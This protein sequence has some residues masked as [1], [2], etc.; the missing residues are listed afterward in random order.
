MTN[1]WLYSIILFCV[2]DT[3]YILRKFK[4]CPPQ[5]VDSRSTGE[6]LAYSTQSLRPRSPAGFY[7]HLGSGFKGTTLE[8]TLRCHH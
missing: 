8:L 6:L 3:K 7:A 4:E 2:L 1:Q 5:N